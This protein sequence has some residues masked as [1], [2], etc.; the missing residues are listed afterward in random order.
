MDEFVYL[1]Q[2]DESIIDEFYINKANTPY[3]LSD[4]ISLKIYKILDMVI[5]YRNGRAIDVLDDEVFLKV[6]KDLINNNSI[7]FFDLYSI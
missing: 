6:L 4:Y 1:P 7:K 3:A 5:K 2:M